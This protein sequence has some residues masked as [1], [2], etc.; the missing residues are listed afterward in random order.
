MNAHTEHGVPASGGSFF[1][2]A[3]WYSLI[4][5]LLT[6]VIWF[7]IVEGTGGYLGVAFI[8]ALCILITSLIS[9]VLGLF[10]FLRHGRK[11]ILLVA[12]IGVIASIVL[13]FFSYAYWGLLQ[14]WHG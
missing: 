11:R 8:W 3:A 4:T 7:A 6:L 13:G 9:G 1:V 2:V 10:G 12:V 5:S 14:T